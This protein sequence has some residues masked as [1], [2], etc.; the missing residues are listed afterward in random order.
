MMSE[1]VSL[2]HLGPRFV[3]QLEGKLLEFRLPPCLLSIQLL[4][5]PEVLQVFVIGPYL[6]GVLHSK[7]V[8]S[9]GL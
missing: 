8:L 3:D 4:G 6:K 2:L 5:L 1:Q 9:P 7:Q